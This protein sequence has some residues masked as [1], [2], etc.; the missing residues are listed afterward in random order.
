MTALPERT[1]IDVKVDDA[2]HRMV[3]ATTDESR[4]LW[5]DR[6]T[7]CVNLRNAARKPEQIAELERRLGLAP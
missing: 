4:R 6:F 1:E 7:A 5:G 3:T 2:Y